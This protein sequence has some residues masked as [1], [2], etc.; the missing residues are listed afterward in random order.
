MFG[1]CSL[2]PSIEKVNREYIKSAKSFDL[3]YIYIKK[4]TDAFGY[5]RMCRQLVG[6]FRNIL[7]C[8]ANNRYI[9]FI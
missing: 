6:I 8:F 7:I 1:T 4:P 9:I 2:V 3:S 5:F